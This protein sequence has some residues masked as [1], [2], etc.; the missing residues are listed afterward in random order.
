MQDTMFLV[1]NIDQMYKEMK[2]I[3]EVGNKHGNGDEFP[4][5]VDL[6]LFFGIKNVRVSSKILGSTGNTHYF[7]CLTN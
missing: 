1:P 4:D 6:I 5:F 3:V 7:F 2:K